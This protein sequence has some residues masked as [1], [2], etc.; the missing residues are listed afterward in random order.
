MGHQ[1]GWEG[2]LHRS[3]SRNPKYYLT[4]S[5]EALRDLEKVRKSYHVKTVKE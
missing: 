4:E 1:F 3:H 2:T 5:K